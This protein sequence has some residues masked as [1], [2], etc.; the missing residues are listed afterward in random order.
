M[1]IKPNFV[2]IGSVKAGTTSL[3][4]YLREHPDICFCNAELQLF[5]P[6]FANHRRMMGVT[7]QM[8]RASIEKYFSGFD[9]QDYK[10]YGEKSALYLLSDHGVE[11]I[12]KHNPDAKIVAM[13]RNP[14]D[15]VESFHAQLLFDTNENIT[16][17]SKAWALQDQRAEGTH[18]PP[19]C[20]EPALLQ[21]KRVGALGT[22][23]ERMMAIVPQGQYHIILFDDFIKDTQ[24]VYQDVLTFLDLPQ[25]GKS[26]FPRF[27]PR[28]FN[29]SYWI[30]RFTQH[31]PHWLKRLQFYLGYYLRRLSLPTVDL[32][33]LLAKM[34]QSNKKRAP[35]STEVRQ[36]LIEALKPEIDKIARITNRNLDHWM[37]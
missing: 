23:L 22:H 34:N 25:D 17:F 3:V 33:S 5:A 21:L 28:K 2:I 18:I 6:E 29:K 9:G 32:V 14:V 37:K 13:I 27:N 15:V 30:A 1:V 24:K 11:N 19:G 20:L 26:E 12:M 10:I 7:E 16:D 36:Q 4:R 8:S 31:R 35:L